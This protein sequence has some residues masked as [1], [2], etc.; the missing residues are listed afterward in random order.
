MNRDLCKKG[1]D[2]MRQSNYSYN[3]IAFFERKLRFF[4][5]CTQIM[6]II[7]KNY[8]NLQCATIQSRVWPAQTG[9]VF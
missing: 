4:C 3:F 9:F 5:N 8:S 6:T 1:M 7:G 2:D